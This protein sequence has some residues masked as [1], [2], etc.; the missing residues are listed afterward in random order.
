MSFGLVG[1]PL[2]AVPL[3]PSI[4]GFAKP[5]Q[6]RGT[7]LDR[8]NQSALL[9]Q[10]EAIIRRTL[11]SRHRDADWRWGQRGGG[12]PPTSLRKSPRNRLCIARV[13]TGSGGGVPAVKAGAVCQ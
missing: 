11:P 8:R 4:T 3:Q 13:A 1:Q 7:T 9:A 6:H 5:I 12:A 10:H 2:V